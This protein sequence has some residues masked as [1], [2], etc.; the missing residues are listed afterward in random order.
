MSDAAP[1]TTDETGVAYYRASSLY[2]CHN[3][4]LMHRLGY[5]GKQPPE[6]MQQKYE[7]GHTWEPI[8]LEKLESAFDFKLSHQQEEI[9]F[10][11]GSSAKV[12]GHIDARGYGNEW[13]QVKVTHIN[14]EKTVGG[15][16]YIDIPDDKFLVVDAKALSKG[17]F[18]KWARGMWR[19]FPYY[20]W[21][22]VIYVIA[23]DAYGL[24]MA[25]KNKDSGELRVDYFT[26]DHLTDQVSRVDIVKKV[27][28]VEADAKIGPQQIF[29]KPCTKMFPC[30]FFNYHPAE[31]KEAEV[32]ATPKMVE[33]VTQ[34]QRYKVAMDNFKTMLDNIDEEIKAEAN[35]A[36]CVCPVPGYRV[37]LYHHKYSVID[38]DLLA[39]NLGI[40]VEDAK[41]QLTKLLESDK[42]TVKVTPI[43]KKGS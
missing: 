43:K 10:A 20:L 8:I 39:I 9:E 14:G 41:E 21:Q 22:Q 34:R 11:V 33:L 29:A 38:W 36:P 7:D 17:S 18:E 5:Q 28:A 27:L 40:P 19:E 12:R 13:G 42:L 30:P 15:D 37:E 35:N 16:L 2:S 3:A 24:V 32:D 26:R 25:V 23:L 1:V 4:L 31:D 6:W